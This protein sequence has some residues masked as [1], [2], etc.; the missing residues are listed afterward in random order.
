MD[1]FS[2]AG[3]VPIAAKS[4][5]PGLGALQAAW[6]LQ[7]RLPM[8]PPHPEEDDAQMDGRTDHGMSR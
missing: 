6:G 3:A 2:V 4:P 1:G 8:S 5:C 7:D